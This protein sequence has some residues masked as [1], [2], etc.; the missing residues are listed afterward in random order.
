MSESDDVFVVDGK[1]RKIAVIVPIRRYNAVMED[2]HDLAVIGERRDEK[3][4]SVK[5]MRRRLKNSGHL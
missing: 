1:G 5:Q 4:I 3:A 2:L